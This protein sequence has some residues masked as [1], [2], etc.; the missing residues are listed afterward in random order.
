MSTTTDVVLEPAAQEFAD[1]TANPPYLFD[2]GPDEGPRG[3]RPG[4]VRRDRRSRTSRSRT[5]SSRAARPVRC[6]SGSC[7]RPERHRAASRDPVHPRRGLGVRQR[8]HPR[9]ADPRAR[10]RHRRRG[11]VPQLQPVAGGALPDRNRGDLRRRS[12]GSPQHGAENGL[13]A[14]RIAVAGDS[15]GGNM[16]AA[17]TL[18]AKQRSRPADRR[19]GAVLPGHRRQLRHRLLPPV[20]RGL[21][22]AP[23]RDAVVLGPVHDRRGPARRDHRVAAARQPSTSSPVCPRR[24]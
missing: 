22:P 7:V 17:M 15:V 11:R 2:L 19:P 10:R 6:R 9:P 16:A 3:R 4:P 21:L 12:S 23:R 20:R 8:P 1:A 14:S 24:W 18:M 13:D 5:R